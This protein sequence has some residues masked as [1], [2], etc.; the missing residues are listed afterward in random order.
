MPT[1]LRGHGDRAANMATQSS[2]HGTPWVIA[3]TGFNRK[4]RQPNRIAR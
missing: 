2:G 4:E 3:N 1:A